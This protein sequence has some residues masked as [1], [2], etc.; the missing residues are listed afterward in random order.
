MKRYTLIFASILSLTACQTLHQPA[1]TTPTTQTSP[2]TF[3]ITGKIGITTQTA[4]GR[5]GGSAF[6]GWKQ[7]GE[8]F[9]INLTGAFGVGTTQIR[10]DGTKATLTADKTQIN[11]DNPNDLLLKATGWHAPIDKLP[12][13]VMGRVA[14]GDT[15]SIFH[16][17]RLTQSKNGDWL[18]VFDYKNALPHRISMTHTD[19]HKVILTINHNQS[20]NN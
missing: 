2:I 8:R 9:A 6:Y 14:Q 13:W 7:E 4:E 5:S 3:D 10:Y 1:P 15:D 16:Q 19:G 11:A 18:A 12:H 17:G 20:P